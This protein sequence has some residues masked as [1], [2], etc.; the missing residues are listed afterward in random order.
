MIPETRRDPLLPAFVT[1]ALCLA[2][3][4]CKEKTEA[5][6]APGAD[7]GTPSAPTLADV[8]GPTTV[9]Y[10]PDPD[11]T[12]C[13]PVPDPFGVDATIEDTGS[14]IDGLPL[15]QVV[16]PDAPPGGEIRGAYDPST[17]DFEGETEEVDQGDGL[18]A[19]ERWTAS[20][21]LGV[22]YTGRSEVT[23]TD[24]NNG[25]SCMLVYDV[26]GSVGGS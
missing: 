5:F 16:F 10:D 14:T 19:V 26:S 2:A 6:F 11:A 22:D 18:T 15:I 12:T 21:V 3:A 7:A 8:T 13:T 9:S 25:A 1:F 23:F 20:F 4:G 24:T 17:G